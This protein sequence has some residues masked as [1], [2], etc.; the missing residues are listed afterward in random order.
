MDSVAPGLSL[1]RRIY[2]CVAAMLQTLFIWTS[3]QRVIDCRWEEAL[4]ESPEDR[5]QTVRLYEHVSYS[6]AL[7][8]L[9]IPPI[10][11]HRLVFFLGW[12]MD[13]SRCRATCFL[14]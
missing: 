10:F 11:F 9:M 7:V 8:P 4:R 2:N 13:P 5:R 1:F 3:L 14:A 12:M 6:V